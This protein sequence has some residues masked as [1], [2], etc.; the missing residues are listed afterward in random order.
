MKTSSLMVGLHLTL[1]SANYRINRILDELVEL[2][3]VSDLGLIRISKSDLLE[4]FGRGC[5]VLTGGTQVRVEDANHSSR[6]HKGI[7]SLPADI[8]RS[9]M[10]KY[11][12][13]SSCIKNL[14]RPPICTKEKVLPIISM[15]AKQLNDPVPPSFISVYRW[16]KKYYD[17]N[18]DILSFIDKRPGKSGCR[19]FNDI[20]LNEVTMLI[21][22]VYLT[23][24]RPSKSDVYRLFHHRMNELNAMRAKPLR[25]PSKSHFYRLVGDINKYEEM[26]A[27]EGKQQADTYFRTVG[28][29][30]KVRHV[31]ERVEVDHTELDVI[32]VN[33]NTGEAEGRPTLT[34]IIDVYSRLVLGIYIGFEPPSQLSVMRALRQAILPK[35]MSDSVYNDVTNKWESFGIPT[36]L[37]CDNGLEFHSDA[38]QRLCGELGVNLQFCPK[39]TP[40][41]KGVV[42]RFI[43]T[44]NTEVCQKLPGATFSNVK[45]RGDYDSVEKSCLSLEEIRNLIYRW[46]ID[47]YHQR[48][49]ST[50]KRSP[51]M[52]WQEGA[53]KFE[54]ML[55]ESLHKLNLSLTLE[56]T[57]TLSHKGIEIFNQFYSAPILREM[58]ER[59]KHNY[60]VTV[61]YDEENIGSIW[62][63]DDLHGDFIR[64]PSINPDYADGLSLRQHKYIRKNLVDKGL[65][66]Q[67]EKAT[68][69]HRAKLFEA[70]EVLK[71]AKLLKERRKGARL[72]QPEQND[73]LSLSNAAPI[74]EVEVNTDPEVFELLPEFDIDKLEE[75]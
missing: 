16:W 45:Q 75:L 57:R 12:Y 37:I 32:S 50:T 42:E 66:E 47:I 41:Y 74:A 61:R 15:V 67:N 4:Q 21:N 64:I 52:L 73:S 56:T 30:P 9:I 22:E 3:R 20:V 10:R 39:K 23:E 38:L 46:M 49:H 7:E 8:Q 60:E 55:P 48:V 27:R 63:Y 65:G 35:L 44:L 53:Q 25:Y 51:A 24:N 70:I 40:H 31:L 71:S 1:N 59:R 54:P 36:T 18:N 6:V 29:G 14:G 43:G 72:S 13:V 2:E 26:A 69:A 11:G 68:L 34:V 19:A 17:C 62:V 28:A 58:R 33:P 5:L